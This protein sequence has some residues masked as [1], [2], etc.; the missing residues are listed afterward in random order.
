M[1]RYT[2]DLNNLPMEYIRGPYFHSID[3][4]FRKFRKS[5]YLLISANNR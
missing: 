3:F 5:P 4:I 1:N 2:N